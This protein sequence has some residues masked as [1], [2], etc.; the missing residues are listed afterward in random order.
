MLDERKAAILAALVEEHI[1]TGEP[2]SS[3]TILDHSPLRCSSATIRNEMVVL[4][5]EGYVVKPHTSA[6]RVPTDRGYRYYIDHLAA[7]P[8]RPSGHARVEQ[9]FASIHLEL[10][11]MLKQ[12]SELLADVAHYPSVVIGP[13]V[14]GQTLRDAHLLPVGPDTVLLVLVTERGRVTQ[15]LL[16][17]GTP[18]APAEVSRAQRVLEETLAGRA[19]EHCPGEDPEAGLHLPAPV[20]RLVE[21][22]RQ[23]VAEA[24]RADRP[25]F[26]GGTSLLATLWEDLAKL[27]RILA[28][29]E[30]EASVLQLVDDTSRQTT[31]RLGAE[32]ASGEEDLAVV[33][34]PYE[35]GG[36]TGRVGLLGPRRMD[37]RRAIETVEEVGGALGDT[38]GDTLG[39]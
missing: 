9:F 18:V 36:A 27:Q 39:G 34:A 30:R 22:A 37:Y 17:L 32:V 6:G 1:R 12:T 31:V 35:A 16:R 2:V 11:R 25:V 10:D 21:R 24:A 38:L 33:S 23:A 8:Q 7:G 3:R 26:L 20:A 5:H 14:Q 19:F 13:P 29:L 28:M 4:E 15:S